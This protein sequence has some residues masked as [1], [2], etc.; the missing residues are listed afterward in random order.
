MSFNQTG[1][2][3]PDKNIANNANKKEKEEKQ[4][5]K[6]RETIDGLLVDEIIENGRKDNEG[7]NGI[8]LKIQ[9]GDL[10][11]ELQ[12]AL[13]QEGVQ[14][15]DRAVKMLKVYK[16]GMGKQ[17][18]QMQEKAR[19][20]IN[21]ADKSPTAKVPK[22]DL[23]KDVELTEKERELLAEM[24]DWTSPEDRAEFLMMDYVEG[25][26]LYTYMIKETAKRHPDLPNLSD[27]EEINKRRFKELEKD[28]QQV[29]NFKIPNGDL[30]GEDEK[31]HQQER[32]FKDNEKVLY[33]TLKKKGAHVN[34]EILDQVKNAID[35]LHEAGY[36][37]R[38]LHERNIM[39][40]GNP[41]ESENGLQAFMIDFDQMQAIEGD[42]VTPGDYEDEKG[43]RPQD[44]AAIGRFEKYFGEDDDD[45]IVKTSGMAHPLS[46]V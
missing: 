14:P 20:I 24:A 32:V 42:R 17:E 43:R 22:P 3:S 23:H 35:A 15:D 12:E 25:D 44:Q 4:A 16:Q 21:E 8:I 27:M 38:D 2:G 37:H 29:L 9:F 39:I 1:P 13:K 31:R 34:R 45:E 26:D 18:F 7:N 40:D 11:S 36:A 19:G 10:S 41:F 30:R 33:N 28:V 5:E 46:D 6:V